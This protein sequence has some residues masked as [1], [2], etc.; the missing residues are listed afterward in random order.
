MRNKKARF[1]IACILAFGLC[2][3]QVG[4]R[5][6]DAST[7]AKSVSSYTNTDSE[8]GIFRYL[9]VINPADSASS[10]KN[11]D[12]AARQVES[13]TTDDEYVNKLGSTL[14]TQMLSFISNDGAASAY[15]DTVTGSE[16]AALNRE[17]RNSGYDGDYTDIVTK[18]R[19]TLPAGTLP[20]SIVK[21][22]NNALFY[23]EQAISRYPAL[24]CLFTMAAL[25]NV[26][27]TLTIYSPV[28]KSDLASTIS[29]YQTTLDDM[30]KVVKD[31]A[32]D[33]NDAEKVLYLHDQV[34][35]ITEYSLGRTGIHAEDYIPAAAM[36]FNLSVCQ[37]YAAVLNQALRAVGLTSYVVYSNTH[38][39][40][41]VRVNGSWYYV[42][43][44]YDDSRVLGE[45]LDTVKHNYVLMGN[46]ADSAHTLSTDYA[47]HF[48][49]DIANHLG[50]AADSFFPS[51]INIKNITSQMTYAN[52][53]FYYTENNNVCKWLRTTSRKETLNLSAASSRRVA[54]LD[55]YV[56]ISGTTGLLKMDPAGS[57]ATR[58]DTD[59][60]TG[61]YEAA[62]KLYV[63]KGG[64][65]NIYLSKSSPVT[66]PSPYVTMSP[67]TTPLPSGYTPGPTISP[68]TTASAGPTSSSKIPTVPP[69]PTATIY[70][71][72]LVSPTPTG[73]TGPTSTPYPDNDSFTVP[74][75]TYIKQLN[76]SATRAAYVKWKKVKGA[77]RY[78]VQ[79]S[80]SKSFNTKQIRISMTSSVTIANLYKNKT[81]YFRVRAV[82]IKRVNG[83][84][85]YK[86][87]PWSAKKK[88]K[89]KK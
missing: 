88:L 79:Y 69:Y 86:Y 42:D 19:F 43:P 36:L 1:R 11:S 31:N 75:K 27:N 28:P 63:S 44:T 20:G 78:Q 40:V 53:G 61:M 66:S 65:Y 29:L 12:S 14:S 35:A 71:P 8:S 52:K 21:M 2:V 16:L 34:V 76:N 9:K 47:S 45:G 46:N 60:I 62:R 22:D 74:A 25:D 24:C 41:A 80:P 4:P 72:T 26:N 70:D 51:Q 73:Y 87:A 48:S 50:G 59:S 7:Q 58:I 57:T 23:L 81:Y 33:M 83:V 67:Y 6:S 89:I 18:V 30:I 49:T 3:A 85:T 77:T 84:I 17:L 15:I 39:W 82:K 56:Y 38:A 55:G 54:V 64:A 5:I 13:L 10:E 68:G 32:S 37:S